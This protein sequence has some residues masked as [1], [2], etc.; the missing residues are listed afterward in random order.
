M[1]QLLI[2]FDFT[3]SHQISANSLSP[4]LKRLRI[5]EFDSKMETDGS[6]DVPLPKRASGDG[7]TMHNV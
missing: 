6:A 3:V 5:E 7:K 2:E 1:R 4:Q